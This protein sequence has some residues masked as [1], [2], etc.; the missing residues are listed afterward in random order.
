MIDAF[1]SKVKVYVTLT[2][3]INLNHVHTEIAEFF[4]KNFLAVIEYLSCEKK[5]SNTVDM[6]ENV[7]AIKFH[8]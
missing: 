2:L 7:N 8:L 3:L 5:V 6:A 1:S 4:F